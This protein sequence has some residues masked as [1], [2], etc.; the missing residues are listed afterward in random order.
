MT[1]DRSTFLSLR[2]QT[3]IGTRNYQKRNQGPI[4]FNKSWPT[5]ER[6]TRSS[7]AWK[8]NLRECE[9]Y[10]VFIYRFKNG[11]NKYI[12]SVIGTWYG[13]R[14]LLFKRIL[15]VVQQ[16][17]YV[18]WWIS[19][20][21]SDNT[22]SASKNKKNTFHLTIPTFLYATI[23]VI[24]LERLISWRG[25]YIQIRCFNILESKRRQFKW[26]FRHIH[27]FV[28][29]WCSLLVFLELTPTGVLWAVSGPFDFLSGFWTL[30]FFKG[31]SQNLYE[32]Q[33]FFI[34]T[35]HFWSESGS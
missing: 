17:L 28:Q 22:N 30:W 9:P 31:S 27:I 32:L 8:Q 35:T 18:Y 33:S 19:S 11:V 2:E 6:G 24:Y 15:N 21:I 14:D 29:A 25:A 3:Q 16:L 23:I 20:P 10:L 34:R 7:T 26:D 4:S 13:W 1:R 12:F 5:W